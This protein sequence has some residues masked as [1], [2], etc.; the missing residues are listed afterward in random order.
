MA[1]EGRPPRGTT[2]AQRRIRTRCQCAWPLGR[3]SLFVAILLLAWVSV[4]PFTN[5]GDERWLDFGDTSDLVNQIA[6]VG[7]GACAAVFMLRNP[8]LPGRRCAPGLWLRHA[9]V[10]IRRPRSRPRGIRR[11]PRGG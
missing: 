7:L 6:Y 10:G 2:P 4:N 3:S 5:L 9:G 1:S 8:Q 11:F